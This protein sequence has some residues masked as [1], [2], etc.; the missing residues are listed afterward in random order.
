MEGKANSLGDE[1]SWPRLGDENDNS[2]FNTRDKGGKGEVMEAYYESEGEDDCKYH[3]TSNKYEGQVSH[4]DRSSRRDGS[5]RDSR[6]RDSSRRDSTEKGLGERTFGESYGKNGYKI[7][8]PSQN[9][10]YRSFERAPGS[11][12]E[13]IAQAAVGSTSEESD[14]KD[15]RRPPQLRRLE[16]FNSITISRDRTEDSSFEK[17][18][19]IAASRENRDAPPTDLVHENS[20]LLPRFR[21]PAPIPRYDWMLSEG[22]QASEIGRTYVGMG[23]QDE[24]ILWPRKPAEVHQSQPAGS[25]AQ[26][27]ALARRSDRPSRSGTPQNFASDTTINQIL[28]LEKQIRIL[29]KKQKELGSTTFQVFHKIESDQTTFLMPPSWS[30]LPKGDW[31]LIGNEPLAN[32]TH[33]LSRRPDIAFIVYSFYGE[34]H[35]KQAMEHAK[36]TGGPLPQ[37]VPLR[38]TIRLYSRKMINAAKNFLEAQPT[39]KKD[40]PNWNSASDIESPFLFWYHYRSSGYLDVMSEPHKGQ[41]RLL[42]GWIDQNYGQIYQDADSKFSR[43]L[44][45]NSTMPFFVRPGEVLVSYDPKGIQGYISESWAVREIPS[46]LSGRDEDDEKKKETWS[47]K[48]WSYSYNGR[49]SRSSSDLPIEF[50]C[51]DDHSDIDIAKLQVLPLRLATDEIRIKLERRGRM[52]WAC[53]NRKLIAYDDKGNVYGVSSAA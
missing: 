41:M 25:T 7:P 4:P 10:G 46:Q 35:Q 51:G 13:V 23:E 47:I 18:L 19:L 29:R 43:G 8:R 21:W 9:L 40:F 42:G 50:E 17:D 37:P 44:V 20:P 6:R 33:Y 16:D 39:F 30:I 36:V 26:N 22:Q 45:S 12:T 31:K 28:E 14:C 48:C 38:E 11:R 1:N 15:D 49:F 27:P 53:R 5:R 3:S 24:E 52:M 2:K 34:G 32:E